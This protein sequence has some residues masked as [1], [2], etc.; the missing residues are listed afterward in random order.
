MHLKGG[1]KETRRYTTVG[2]KK[3]KEK[4]IKRK[5]QRIVP[6]S[7]LKRKKLVGENSRKWRRNEKRGR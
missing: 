6:F 4:M 3:R 7:Q 1:K 5:W 2:K